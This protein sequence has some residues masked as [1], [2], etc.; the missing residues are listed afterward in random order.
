MLCD[1][2]LCEHFRGIHLDHS[3]KH[4]TSVNYTRDVV[5]HVAMLMKRTTLVVVN[6]F[7]HGKVHVLICVTR[8]EYII[9]HICWSNNY[10]LNIP[11]LFFVF[12]CIIDVYILFTFNIIG[13]NIVICFCF[14]NTSSN[15]SSSSSDI[16]LC[17]WCTPAHLRINK[18]CCSKYVWNVMIII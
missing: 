12:L 13:S 8:H 4:L 17:S 15:S 6:S 14:I 18:L 5:Q 7:D 11:L 1:I 2:K 3:T 9:T 10:I 16:Y